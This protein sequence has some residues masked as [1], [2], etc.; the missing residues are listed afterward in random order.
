MNTLKISIFKYRIAGKISELSGS[1]RH[2]IVS[3]LAS[4]LPKKQ[5]TIKL[6]FVLL[7]LKNRTFLKILIWLFVSDEDLCACEQF[8]AFL[9]KTDEIL[10]KNTQLYYTK[11]LSFIEFI[12]I[13]EVLDVL[14]KEKRLE[15]KEP[16][17]NLIIYIAY[18]FIGKKY[19]DNPEPHKLKHIQSLNINV[20]HDLLMRV[21]TDFENLL[22]MLPKNEATAESSPANWFQI[23]RT[24]A[25]TPLNFDSV[26]NLDAAVVIFD[27]RERILEIQRQ[28]EEL[29]RQR[30]NDK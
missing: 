16:E 12:R 5:L 2:Q 25:G 13:D 17:A 19:S 26:A 7:N 8:T 15:F 10:L 18:K 28:K 14:R 20:K 1:Q 22:K 21:L 27:L 3:L 23:L 4:N 30:A 29:E 11:T 24:I 9:F 6:L